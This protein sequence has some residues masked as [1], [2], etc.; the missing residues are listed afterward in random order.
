[1]NACFCC[2]TGA[3]ATCAL[4][5]IKK[6][7]V[8]LLTTKAAVLVECRVQIKS[9]FQVNTNITIDKEPIA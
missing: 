9:F 2:L 4:S 5:T 3:A 7:C 1:M 6:I 8:E